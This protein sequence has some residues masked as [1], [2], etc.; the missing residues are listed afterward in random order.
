MEAEA[1]KQLITKTAVNC[2]AK[3]NNDMQ[4]IEVYNT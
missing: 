2:S 4:V 1:I 3:R